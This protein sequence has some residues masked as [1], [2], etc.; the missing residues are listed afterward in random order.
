VPEGFY[1][2]NAQDVLTGPSSAWPAQLSAIAGNGI[3]LVRSDARWWDVEPSAP[4]ASAHSYNWSK[5]DAMVQALASHGLRWYP[6][7]SSAP[8]W[9]AP[10]SGDYTPVASHIGDFAAY[11]NAFARRYGRGGSFWP[12]HRSLSPQPVTDYEI[13]NEQNSTKFW[14]SQADAPERYA[15]VYA[16]ARQAIKA[17]DAQA[18][19]VIGGLALSNPPSVTDEIQFLSRMLAHRPDLRGAV[20]GVGLH[21]YQPTVGDT[22]VRLSSVRQTVDQLLGRAVPIDITEVGWSTTMVSDSERASDLATLAVQLPQSNCNV[23]RLLP[24]SWLSNESDGSNA[25]DWFGIW[26]HNG[27]PKPSGVSYAQAV[28]NMR[29][30]PSPSAGTLHLC[31]GPPAQALPPGPR[32]RLRVVVNGPGRRLTVRARCPKGCALGVSLRRRHAAKETALAHRSMRFSS[33]TRRLRFRIPRRTHRL[34]VAVMATG[35]GGGRTA[36]VRS[37]RLRR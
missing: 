15:D 23:D 3:Q 32:L 33:R 9:A 37:I 20:D 29:A 19:V 22:F 34:K 31:A 1:G 14:A 27:Q 7:L 10:R 21:P 8:G 16:A 24:Y 30:L 6:I 12:A 13:W 36:R 28:K 2:I 17:A 18:R 25:E 26:N 4:R 11:A 35:R 5:Y